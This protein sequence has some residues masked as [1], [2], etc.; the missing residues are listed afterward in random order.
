MPKF[1]R[2]G[3]TAAVME[4]VEQANRSDGAKTRALLAAYD[5][6]PD[7]Q[8]KALSE[9]M[10]RGNYTNPS[11]GLLVRGQA[12]IDANLAHENE[13]T[14]R[15]YLR[16]LI[17]VFTMRSTQ[18][19][20]AALASAIA[21]TNEI[22]RGLTWDGV[23][24]GI[25][26]VRLKREL[27][28]TDAQ[29]ASIKQTINEVA[30][31]GWDRNKYRPLMVGCAIGQRGEAGPGTLGCFVERNG[32]IFILSNY[33]VLKQSAKFGSMGDNEIL[34]PAHL[35]GGSY[36]D[37]VADYV[38]GEK[39]LDAAIARV[40]RGIVVDNRTTG[41]N[42]FNISGH[43]VNVADD[44]LIKKHGASTGYRLGKISDA[45]AITAQRTDMGGAAA[46]TVSNVKIIRV[47][48]DAHP[49]VG[50]QVQGDSGTV[51]CNMADQVLG[52]MNVKHGDG[53]S[54]ATLID[55]ILRRFNVTIL[56]AG[57]RVSPGRIGTLINFRTKLL[58][59][60]PNGGIKHKLHWDSDTNDRAD[61]G[62]I[63]IREHVSWPTPSPAVLPYIIDPQPLENYRVAGQHYGVGNAAVTPGTADEA[64]DNHGATGL[65]KPA[66]V[67]YRGAADLVVTFDQVYEIKVGTAAWVAIPNSRYTVERRIRAMPNNK[68]RVILTKTNV[69]IAADSISNW[70]EL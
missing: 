62:H 66:F 28:N 12:R 13:K 63:Q 49:N 19:F 34:Q 9:A 2:V 39:T 8:R 64:E 35:V 48:A 68:V 65:F 36:H 51:I 42:A 18:P 17:F 14:C 32:E 16:G 5:N 41:P 44:M 61:L 27:E 54:L 15:K 47:P 67:N 70:V 56:P 3:K 29:V 20:D 25:L 55:P 50:F 60:S 23:A 69:T 26:D 59:A 53:S 11:P 30:W 57:Q 4:G 38:D 33:H 31:A 45:T 58:Q 24:I 43:S 7:R 6:L 21:T 52:L 46:T 37:V 40:R 1:D 10:G 22:A